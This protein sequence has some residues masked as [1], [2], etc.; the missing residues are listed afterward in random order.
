VAEKKSKNEQKET[1]F[2]HT[3]RRLGILNS[4]ETEGNNP[5]TLTIK[6]RTL[7][8]LGETCKKSLSYD[9]FLNKLLDLYNR[10]GGF[11]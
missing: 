10:E 7:K 1:K 2:S 3:F 8:R 5:T 4:E 9:E 6:K 11:E